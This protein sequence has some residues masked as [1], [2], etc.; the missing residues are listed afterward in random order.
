[1]YDPCGTSAENMML[2]AGNISNTGQ[3]FIQLGETEGCTSDGDPEHSDNK[4]W[5]LFNSASS[6]FE[7]LHTTKAKWLIN[8]VKW[9][10]A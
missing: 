7:L 2:R 5:I 4:S 6:N 9:L 1:V 3:V 8:W 10:G